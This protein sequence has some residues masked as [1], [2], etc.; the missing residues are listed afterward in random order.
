MARLIDNLLSLNRIEMRLHLR[1]QGRVDMT[2]IAAHV[3]A[4]ARTRGGESDIAVHFSIADEPLWVQGDR[5]ELVQVIPISSKTPSN[6]AGAAA[7]SG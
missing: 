5:D 1:P 7:T 3:A 2:D 4:D 6:M